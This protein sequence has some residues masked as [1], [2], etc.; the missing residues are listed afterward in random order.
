MKLAIMQP[1]FLPY[2][3]YFQLM[4]AADRFIVYDDVNFITRGYIH[5]NKIEINGEPKWFGVSIKKA[6]QNRKINETIINPDP[7]WVPN[8]KRKIQHKYGKSPHFN[9]IYSMLERWLDENPLKLSN[10]LY[11][12]LIDIRDYLEIDTELTLSSEMEQ[13]QKLKGVDRIMDICQK[14]GADTYYN[15]VGGKH[16][17][18]PKRFSAANI[19]LRFIEMLGDNYLSILDSLMTQDKKEIQKNLLR[20]RLIT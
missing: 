9:K 14:Q 10:L 20:Y 2:L 13:D 15:S 4:K 1:Y 19:E 16:L 11:H 5:R 7:K 6:S 12:Q 3:G 18:D 8:L 17:Y